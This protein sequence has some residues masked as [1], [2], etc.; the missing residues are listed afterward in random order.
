MKYVKAMQEIVDDYVRPLAGAGIEITGTAGAATI[1][2]V[3]PLAGAGIE[4]CK[5]DA[6]NR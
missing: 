4:I 3:R 6:R 5:G 1:S 2:M